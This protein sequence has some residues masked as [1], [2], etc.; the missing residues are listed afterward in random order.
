MISPGTGNGQPVE[1]DALDLDHR[2]G[3]PRAVLAVE[4]EHDAG[5]RRADEALLGVGVVLPADLER[6]EPLLAEVDRL[7]ERPPLEIPEV[8][9]L[10][11]PA[12]ADVGE[13]EARLVRVRLAE[14]RRDEDVLAR[15]VPEVVV[16]RRPRAAVLPAA[17]HL[18][19]L[20]VDDGEPPGA[21][22]VGVAEHRD[23]DVVAGHAV[24][25]VRPRVAGRGDHLLRLDHLLDPRPS[26]VV[27][28]V[29]DVEPRRAE[30]GH[31]QVRAVGPVA[32]GR[33]AIP[34][35]VVQ[36]VAD[37]RHRQL[38]DDPAL[39]RV[40]DGEEVR[41]GD[42]RALVQAGEVEELLLRRRHRVLW[43]AVERRGSLVF[44]LHGVSLRSWVSARPARA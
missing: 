34:A 2:I 27:G 40:D 14:L 31:D 33:A 10:P 18:E 26:R 28:D 32:G 21:V 7:L 15:L 9:P 4:A 8:D 5:Q 22:A 12:G 25:G 36:L 24:H 37:V 11:V 41:L 17:L 35:E 30:A 38:V 43:R 3:R 20:R 39:L 6:H 16:E 19:R 44:V 13:V 29:D 23:D 1:L 42:A